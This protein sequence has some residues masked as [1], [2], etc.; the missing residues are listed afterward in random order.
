MNTRAEPHLLV[1]TTQAD[2]ADLF[3]RFSSDVE[4][5]AAE[6]DR[7]SVDIPHC[8]VLLSTAHHRFMVCCLADT[9]A[10]DEAAYGAGWRGV[11]MVGMVDTTLLQVTSL[12]CHVVS[13]HVMSCHILSCHAAAGH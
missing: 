2:G 6:E 3:I 8:S 4:L 13:C 1:I 7:C 11:R 5:L 9:A 10:C 12:S